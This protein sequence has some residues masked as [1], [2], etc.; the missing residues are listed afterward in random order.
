M[1]SFTPQAEATQGKAGADASNSPT[2]GAPSSSDTGHAPSSTADASNDQASSQ[3][4][5]NAAKNSAG[6]AP[7]LD[8]GAS[9]QL[10]STAAQAPINAAS[11]ANNA[12]AAAQVAAA[13]SSPAQTA[14]PM[15]TSSSLPMPTPAAS[16]QVALSLHQAVK[17]GNDYIQIQL[18]PA[19]LG[20]V[21][22]K[23]NINHDGH[24]TMVV[25]ADRSDTLNMLKQ[26]ASSLTQALR[27]AGLQADNSSLSFNL[28]G[29]YQF[30]QQ[31]QSSNGG[32]SLS[33]PYAN[34]AVD[35]LA[36][37]APSPSMLSSHSGSLD[38]RV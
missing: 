34:G 18:Q 1:A 16:E 4:I 24:V 9:D 10:T 2:S 20:A 31:Q 28:R 19:D 15:A 6:V 37:A 38:I 26:D 17:G 25:S 30:N 5:A 35:D 33:T 13:P 3:A 32:T 36:A 14:A 22:V 29:G 23:L 27:D 21:A 11:A 8:H 7:P 12:A